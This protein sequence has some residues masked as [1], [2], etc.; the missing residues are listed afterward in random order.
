MRTDTFSSFSCP[1]KPQS[2]TGFRT[3]DRR[4]KVKVDG[5]IGELWQNHSYGLHRVTC[6]ADVLPDL[7]RLCRFKSIELVNET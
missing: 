4:S 3:L 6:Y 5:S 1:F 7:K 2:V